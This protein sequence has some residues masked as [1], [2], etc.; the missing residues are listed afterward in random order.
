MYTGSTDR[1]IY[2]SGIA[3]ADLS[4]FV[5]DVGG[6]VFWGMLLKHKYCNSILVIRWKNEY[7]RME[8]MHGKKI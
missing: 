3:F 1:N 8:A 7:R 4:L 2:E 6:E 5:F